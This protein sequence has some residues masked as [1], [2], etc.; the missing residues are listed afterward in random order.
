MKGSFLAR[1]T[2]VPSTFGSTNRLIGRRTS[3]A[4]GAMY[5]SKFME[6][7]FSLASHNEERGLLFSTTLSGKK[8]MLTLDYKKKTTYPSDDN[9]MP[10]NTDLKARPAVAQAHIMNP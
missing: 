7:S 5:R 1:A 8:D 9:R 3:I 10:C 6:F 2:V 4:I